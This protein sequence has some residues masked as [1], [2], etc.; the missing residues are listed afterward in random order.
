MITKVSLIQVI[1]KHVEL[2]DKVTDTLASEVFNLI[3]P[4]LPRVDLIDED[5]MP[6]ESIGLGVKDLE[7]ILVAVE[8]L[9]EI[10]STVT[11]QYVED[12]LYVDT[13]K[14]VA[15]KISEVIF[16]HK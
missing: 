11:P 15:F 14:Q 13:L 8:K 5:N 7:E 16:K 2:P 6:E 4:Y 3:E 1:Q 9:K 12:S 10:Y